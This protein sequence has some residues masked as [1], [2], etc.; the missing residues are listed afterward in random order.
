MRLLPSVLV[1][2]SRVG[3]VVLAMVVIECRGTDP[4][5]CPVRAWR[6]DGY[7][8]RRMPDEVILHGFDRDREQRFRCKP[9]GR[10]FTLALAEGSQHNLP[11]G[12]ASFHEYLILETAWLVDCM[13]V[14][15]NTAARMAGVDWKTARRWCS[16]AYAKWG[17]VLCA[18]L[19]AEDV[20]ADSVSRVFGTTSV[21]SN[22]TMA[23]ERWMRTVSA[24]RLLL[25]MRR[26]GLLTAVE[27]NDLR[28][29]IRRSRTFDSAWTDE[30]RS[31]RERL[32][33]DHATA[34][35]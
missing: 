5:K 2:A 32:L 24:A 14:K 9:C 18:T 6:V 21:G 23:D 28:W 31:L 20:D 3:R 13:G 7:A 12:V 8:S 27:Y 17:S 34:P 19:D 11:K 16:W 35:S 4:Q 30:V 15:M 25:E 1:S 29:L 22:G 33:L 10:T 26:R